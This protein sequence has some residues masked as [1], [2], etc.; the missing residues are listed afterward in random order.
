[1][2]IKKINE[3]ELECAEVWVADI[4]KLNEEELMSLL[5]S[6]PCLGEFD[7]FST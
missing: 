6:N 1:M 7:E 5:Y 4:D 2:E 3:T